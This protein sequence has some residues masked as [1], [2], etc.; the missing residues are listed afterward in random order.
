MLFIYRILRYIVRK[1]KKLLL[2]SVSRKRK[3]LNEILKSNQISV[4]VVLGFLLLIVI[5]WLD[6][7]YNFTYIFF[8]IR[9]VSHAWEEALIQT[10]MILLV[11]VFTFLAVDYNFHKRFMMESQL[12]HYADDLKKFQMAVDKASDHIVITNSEGTILYA[13]QAV[14]KIT[15]FSTGEVIGKKA[16]SKELWGGLMDRDVYRDMWR[17][18]R[19][20]KKT[21]I[22]EIV[23]K[24]KD[25]EKYD[26]EVHISPILDEHGKIMFY[27]GIEIDVTKAKEIERAKSE[28]VSL[29][30]HQLRTPLTSMSLSLDLLLK[31]SAGELNEEQKEYLN[32]IYA[33]IHHTADLVGALLNLSR[34]E[35]GTFS[36]EPETI[37][38]PEMI[39]TIIGELLPQI[40]DKNIELDTLYD[41]GLSTVLTD[42]SILK[43]VVQNLMSN[44]VKYTE[45]GGKIKVEAKV[46]DSELCISVMDTGLGIPK[47]DQVKLFT[48]FFRARN[49]V[50][51]QTNG[52]G[53]G[54]NLSKSLL[55][56]AGGKIWFES[57]E[58]KGTTFFI[59]IPLEKE[60]EESEYDY[61][62]D[63]R[64]NLYKK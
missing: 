45:S 59:K 26:A 44:S 32:D 51:R 20:Q 17:T 11:G 54:L 19:D 56:A 53:L 8:G 36:V 12:R 57:E 60:E 30:S 52:T 18:I 14:E 16:G 21:F 37:H 35:M 2:R 64:I 50:E 38:V 6:E 27:V 23:N 5:A 47:R 4:F 55:E 63:S 39:E 1:A 22:G 61:L 34:I 25:G 7:Y 9:H 58:N 31:G 40:R 48:K 3:S 33:D 29:A 15:G 24:R 62:R 28:F 46:E 49:V 41:V 42:K 43:V 13:N 10:L